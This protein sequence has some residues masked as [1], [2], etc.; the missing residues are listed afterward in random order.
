M[1]VKN[2]S[3]SR[4]IFLSWFLV[5]FCSYS[6]PGRIGVSD[7][8]LQRTYCYPCPNYICFLCLHANCHACDCVCVNFKKLCEFFLWKANGKRIHLAEAAFWNKYSSPIL[9]AFHESCNREFK[10]TSWYA[11]SVYPCKVI[12]FCPSKTYRKMCPIRPV[13]GGLIEFLV[14]V[15][16]ATQEAF[17]SFSNSSQRFPE[18]GMVLYYPVISFLK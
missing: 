7:R 10:H 5:S 14:L 11:I 2:E 15:S 1:L 12:Q 4:A 9:F 3:T 13:Q 6:V 16:P 18:V 8:A 17:Q